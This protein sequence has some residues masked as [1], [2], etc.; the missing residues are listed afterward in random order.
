VRYQSLFVPQGDHQLHLMHIH[1]ASHQGTPVLMIH[2]MVEDGRIF[3][4]RSGKGLGSYLARHGYNVYIADLRGIGQSTPTIHRHS[5]HGQTE[6]IRDDIPALMQFVLQHSG[7][8]QL[9]LAAHSWGGVYLNA[10][11]LR[12]PQLI[13]NVLSSVYFGSKRTVRAR[14]LDRYFR[15]NLVWNR[16]AKQLTRRQGY[17]P[18]VRYKLGSD[19]ET[20]KTHQQ[21][22][23]WVRQE[24]WID[25]DDGFDYGQAAKN[26]CLPD[27]LYYAALRDF[28]LG[29]RFDVKRFAKESGPHRYQ[30]RLLSRQQ[31]NRLDYDHINM[32]TAPQCVDDHFPEVLQW[33]QQHPPELVDCPA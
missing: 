26:T 29:H 1:Q 18:A 20:R 13:P 33:L 7:Q 25:S 11:L 3:Y 17:L 16:F 14:N 4:H 19:N 31:G 12:A 5:A 24:H 9:H 6:T 30:Y 2:G 28:S 23:D 21:C 10:A 32:L 27:T 8:P 15:I 22:V